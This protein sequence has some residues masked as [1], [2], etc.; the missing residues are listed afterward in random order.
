M[1]MAANWKYLNEYKRT[2]YKFIKI[3]YRIAYQAALI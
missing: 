3:V 1:K 2:N